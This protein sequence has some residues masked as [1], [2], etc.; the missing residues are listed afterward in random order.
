MYVISMFR[1]YKKSF[2]ISSNFEV[3]CLTNQKHNYFFEEKK[4]HTQL[5]RIFM[6]FYNIVFFKDCSQKVHC[7][8]IQLY[9]I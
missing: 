4:Q 3:L 1:F 7:T 9:V 5:F 8:T 2:V 6:N